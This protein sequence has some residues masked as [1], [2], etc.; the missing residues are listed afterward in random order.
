MTAALDVVNGRIDRSLFEID[1][2]ASRLGPDPAAMFH[3]VRDEI[4]YEPY[5]GILR[6][7]L[8]TLICRAGNSLD[9]SLLLAALLQKAGLR[10]QIA[11]GQLDPP[12]AQTLAARL[13]EPEKQAPSAI[14]PGVDLA[15]EVSRALGVEPR[16]FQRTADETTKLEESRK[17]E[18]VDYVDGET[19]FLSGL[20]S[21]A[22]VDAGAVT[23]IDRLAAEASEHYWVQYQDPEGKWVDLDSAFPGSE[24]GKVNA[25]ATN[26]FASDSMPEELYHHLRITL[27]LRVAQ[28]AN[29]SDGPMADTAL[30]DQELR[31]ADQ[32][33]ENILLANYPVPAPDLTNPAADRTTIFTAA[34]G[35]QTV[36]Q[37]GE[38]STA[39][40]YFDLDGRV[41]DN[42]S[43]PEGAAAANAGGIGR[44]IGNLSGGFSS[45]LSGGS[46]QA[47]TSR[48]VGEWASYR[49]TSPGVRGEQPSVRDYHRDI[50]PPSAV[51]SWSASTPDT[52]QTIPTKLGKDDL[53]KRLMWSVELLPVTGSYTSDYLAYLQIKSL[54]ENRAAMDSS[55]RI[56]YRLPLSQPPAS[57]AFSPP[58]VNVAL[59]SETAGG[60]ASLISSKFPSIRTYFVRPGLI[61][62][63]F[64]CFD[65]DRGCASG[66]SY[67]IVCYPPRTV[68]RST[69]DAQT[70]RE[71]SAYVHIVQGVLA[72]RMEWALLHYNRQDREADVRNVTEIFRIARE[73]GVGT[74]TLRPGTAGQQSLASLSLPNGIKSEMSASLHAGNT[75]VVPVRP[76]HVNGEPQIGW[77]QL[78]EKSG[79]LIGTMPGGRG[80]AM[81][82][83][84][85]TTKGAINLFVG[86]VAAYTCAKQSNVCKAMLCAGGVAIG[87][88]FSVFTAFSDIGKLLT[89]VVVVTGIAGC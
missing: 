38:R 31:T 28:V 3:F 14:S 6:G 80:Q 63:E 66:E 42:P 61:A 54:L 10:T 22:G 79:E 56:A 69:S 45:A 50:I 77:W 47:P 62:H 72:T 17:K 34:K 76:L 32:Q 21:K 16:Q 23:S 24:P 15:T 20:F 49:L 88:Y 71:A 43:S 5:T 7:A 89:G 81:V 75:L 29:G 8:G 27:T 55:M 2:L 84:I 86:S 41:S 4:R 12:A 70:V 83:Q 40:K 25:Q 26:I 85:M 37:I 74:T 30:I 48:I 46:A 36:L 67:D 9:R 35:Y 58:L 33:G 82:D 68:S 44:S 52:P 39:G 73:Q 53:R 18:L 51:Q 60:S 65:V 1:A 19:N 11:A 64:G 59:S 87:F 57:R 13:F 78:D